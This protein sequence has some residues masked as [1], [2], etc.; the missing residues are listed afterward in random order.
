MQCD[1]QR[2]VTK[3]RSSTFCLLKQGCFFVLENIELFCSDSLFKEKK[4]TVV[5]YSHSAVLRKVTF[6]PSSD[7]TTAPV[8]QPPL[9]PLPDHSYPLVSTIPLYVHETSC[10]S[11]PVWV[12]ACGASLCECWP[13]DTPVPPTLRQWQYITLFMD[14]QSTR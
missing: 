14:K 2:T 8:S 9:P 12:R 3:S 11:F 5:S 6:S 1:T 7:S 4:M 10:C 13:L